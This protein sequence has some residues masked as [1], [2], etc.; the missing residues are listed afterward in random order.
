[1]ELITPHE[2]TETWKTGLANSLIPFVF[3]P[4]KDTK[5]RITSGEITNSGIWNIGKITLNFIFLKISIPPS[6]WTLNY[7]L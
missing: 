3:V 2:H 1:M 4:A 6:K 5:G 7:H